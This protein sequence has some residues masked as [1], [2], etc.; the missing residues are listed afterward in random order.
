MKRTMLPVVGILLL[1]ACNNAGEPTTTTQTDSTNKATAFDSTINNKKT[2][3]YHL[4]NK[5]GMKAAITNYGGR[6]VSLELPDKTGKSTDVVVGFSSV[7]EYIRSTEPYFGATIGRVGNRI[8][9]GVFTLND[10]TYRLFT[11][12]G[13]NTLHGGKVGFQ[14][15]VW[16]AEQPNDSTLILTYVSP[17]GE[18]GFPGE[19]TST[20]RFTITSEQGLDI[21]YTAT[22][23]KATPVNLTNHAF[24]N[25]NGEGSG[26]INNH[27]LQIDA[28]NYTPVDSTLI[29]TGEIAKVD[30]TPFD[31][32]TPVSIGKR[33][34]EANEQLKYGMG[35][36]HNY[37]LDAKEDWKK[38]GVITGDLSGIQME[39][40]TNEPG[41]QF[42]GGNFMGGKNTFKA[43]STDDFRTAF[44]LETQ[45]FPD[46]VNQPSFPSIILQPGK[47]YQT[48]TLYKFSVQK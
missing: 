45:H 10:S 37:V 32:R 19:L 21:S 35:Y 39:I 22:T 30:G 16:D 48:R 31:F 1:A 29:P 7:G 34:D 4:S 38:A 36:D 5:T 42:Y 8:A 20:V 3:L 44:S 47:T 26:T 28:A 17:D 46:A 2:S 41:L 6:I 24:F 27:V 18:E 11:N 14:S 12:N 13:P 43:G 9:K 23:T 25:L 40:W 15:V 33:V